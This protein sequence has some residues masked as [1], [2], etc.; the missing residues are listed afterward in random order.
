[1]SDLHSLE[2]PKRSAKGIGLVIVTHVVI[3]WGL[4]A[5]LTTHFTKKATPP[6]TLIEMPDKPRTVEPPPP[7]TRDVD[8]RP[9]ITPVVAPH[10]I[11]IDLPVSPITVD[12]TSSSKPVE[13]AGTGGM[14]GTGSIPGTRGDGVTPPAGPLRAE[15]VCDVMSMP[16]VPAVNWSGRASFRVQAHLVAGRVAGVQFLQVTGG[17]DARS[18]RALQNAV[19]TAL[20][21]YQCRGSQAFEQEFVFNIQ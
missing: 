5:G 19:Q 14:A 9:V 6:V 7:V 18:R 12:P 15:A 11:T 2:L 1:M 3:V 17:M 21:A 4:A 8:F 20:A 13:G 16:E 10:D